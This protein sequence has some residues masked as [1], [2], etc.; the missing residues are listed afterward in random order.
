MYQKVKLPNGEECDQIAFH[1]FTHFKEGKG[2]SN[3]EAESKYVSVIVML[4]ILTLSHDL[5]INL[6][7]N[8]MKF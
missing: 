8:F 6:D 1:K 7:V 5:H 2:W 4:Y 3:L